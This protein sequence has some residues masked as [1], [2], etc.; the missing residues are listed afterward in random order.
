LILVI[1]PKK[2]ATF[3]TKHSVY[4]AAKQAFGF[5]IFNLSWLPKR[6]L[7]YV[8]VIVGVKIK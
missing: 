2:T 4:N 5:R 1:A 7:G 3:L 8:F 6:F